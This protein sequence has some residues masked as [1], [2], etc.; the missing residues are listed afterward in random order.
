MVTHLERATSIL[1][2]LFRGGDE[3]ACARAWINDI[4]YV[5]LYC[6]L[7]IFECGV[8]NA[9]VAICEGARAAACAA[10]SVVVVVSTVSSFS[11]LTLASIV[12]SDIPR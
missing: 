6:V 1:S 11:I 8:G 3:R 2:K 4:V 12:S 7:S 10:P 5:S 9:D